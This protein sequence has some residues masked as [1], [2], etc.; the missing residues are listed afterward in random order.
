MYLWSKPWDKPPLPEK[1][2]VKQE[3]EEVKPKLEAEVD[4]KQ[5][6]PN[7]SMLMMML[8]NETLMDN[9]INQLTTAPIIPQPEARIETADCR[10][11]LLEHIAHCESLVEERLNDFDKILDE[12]EN[13]MDI[14]KDADYTRTRQT[15]QMLTRDLDKLKEFSR[16][17]T[18]LY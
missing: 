17:S 16:I 12:L 15:L 7:E 1:A 14:E 8:K 3:L 2:G 10:L 4:M 18:N 9:A 6:Q 11:N 5:E 13:G